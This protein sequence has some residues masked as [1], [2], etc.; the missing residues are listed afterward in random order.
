MAYGSA[1][2][3][4][5]ALVFL[6]TGPCL[7]TGAELS[8]E[9][10]LGRYQK[11]VEQHPQN[12]SYHNA[13][14][15]YHMRAGNLQEAESHFQKAIE[16]DGRYATAHNNL[17][18]LYLRV[19]R[20]EQAEEQFRRAVELNPDYSKAQYNLAVALFRQEQ[21]A[22]AAKAYIRAR[23]LDRDYVSRRDNLDKMKQALEET[24]KD[25]ESIGKV[26]RMKQWFAPSY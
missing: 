15:Y 19:G 4:S 5:L 2:G 20:P 25:D 18:I 11:L 26:R 22:E 12:G 13:L 24:V 1:I 14:G 17:G 21:Y 3:A 6:V 9:Q 23:Q 7:A 16:L 8:P 10:G